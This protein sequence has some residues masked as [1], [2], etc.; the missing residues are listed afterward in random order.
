[1]YQAKLKEK[2]QNTTETLPELGEIIHVLR[3][4]IHPNDGIRLAFWCAVVFGHATAFN[5]LVRIP[6]WY[7]K[8]SSWNSNVLQSWAIA[9]NSIGA[10]ERLI[11]HC[12]DIQQSE[13]NLE[14]KRQNVREQTSRIILVQGMSVVSRRKVWGKDFWHPHITLGQ[15]NYLLQSR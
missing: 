7:C 3:R 5:N 13:R 15:H 2:R 11:S 1:M 12:R 8:I 4:L 9:E 6:E 10:N 14:N